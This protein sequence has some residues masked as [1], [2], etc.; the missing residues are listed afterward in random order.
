M[1]LIS[2]AYG[3]FIGIAK[4]VWAGHLQLGPTSLDDAEACIWEAVRL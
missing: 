3:A 1:L 4:G 2:L